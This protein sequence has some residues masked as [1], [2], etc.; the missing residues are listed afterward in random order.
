MTANRTFPREDA[1]NFS[2]RF[3]EG[4][5]PNFS[6]QC[7]VWVEEQL[8]CYARYSTENIPELTCAFRDD[9]ERV[10]TS[11]AY[12]TLMLVVVITST[13]AI[14]LN[15]VVLLTIGFSKK[16]HTL[17]NYL[18]SLLCIS[19]LLWAFS[20][21]IEASGLL[22]LVPRLCVVR[23]LILFV[24]TSLNFGCVVAITVL[25]YLMVVRNQNYPANWKNLVAFTSLVLLPG[26]LHIIP[27]LT[28]L[29]AE[30][31]T[32][33]GRTP[34]GHLLTLPTR[35][36]GH[37]ETQIV[38]ITEYTTGFAILAFCYVRILVKV[39]TARRAVES[40]AQNVLM[41]R[42]RQSAA[43][44]AQWFCSLL[45]KKSTPDPASTLQHPPAE[46][47]SIIQQPKDDEANTSHQS[48]SGL[49]K[50]A[51]H[52]PLTFGPGPSR[53]QDSASS[54]EQP[55]A[56]CS[57]AAPAE[58]ETHAPASQA[59]EVPTEGPPAHCEILLTPSDLNIME[60]PSN[61]ASAGLGA[62]SHSTE[63]VQRSRGQTASRTPLA[64]DRAVRAQQV[65]RVDVVAT[66]ATVAYLATFIISFAP[67]LIIYQ[68][69]KD[70][71]CVV[72]ASTRYYVL[73]MMLLSRGFSAAV[74]PLVSVVFSQDFRAAFR[75]CCQK[76]WRWVRDLRQDT[77]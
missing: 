37:I 32:L 14:V 38:M 11:W 16:L 54:P 59:V 28:Y 23:Y 74:N 31:G 4:L 26:V 40:S 3:P 48:A 46:Q 65:G 77:R 8:E 36:E 18:V 70:L 6:N 42:I 33:L 20:P 61:E 22:V 24:T 47:V 2:S 69:T 10:K 58:T 53:P 67:S 55:E 57:S 7:S 72:S 52:V 63:G 66:M 35:R 9:E 12:V 50:V 43:N 34:A 19:Q 45:A 49:Q 73:T 1:Q 5:I 44:R 25:R 17:V 76:W 60:K 29:S 21:A 75:H 27:L 62:A 56:G 64:G 15:L 30:C 13:L 39:I 68:Y 71:S 51:H 41:T